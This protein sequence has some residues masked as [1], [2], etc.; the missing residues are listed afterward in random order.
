MNLFTYGSLMSPDIMEEVSGRQFASFAAVADGFQ[1]FCVRDEP[2]PGMVAAPGG[3]VEG[4]VYE[5]I[6]PVALE[7]LDIFEGDMYLR[8]SIKVER[9]KDNS[10]LEV[11]AY[12]VKPD[13]RHMLTQAVWSYEKFLEEG[14]RL[15]TEQ[16]VGFR[17]IEDK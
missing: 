14:K 7:R 17:E 15:F 3:Q 12:I 8:Q 2:Y 11:M 16:Y 13:Y 6:D 9:R 10:V 4:V 5:D 1:R